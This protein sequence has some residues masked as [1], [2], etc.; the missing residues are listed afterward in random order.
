MIHSVTPVE[1]LLQHVSH[2][3]YYQRSIPGFFPKFMLWAESIQFERDIMIWNNKQYLSKPLLVKEDSAIQRHRRWYS[4]F[5]SARSVKF[6]GQKNGLDWWLQYQLALAMPSEPF[7][8]SQGQAM[9]KGAMDSL[10]LVVGCVCVHG[11]K[12]CYTE[13]CLHLR[14]FLISSGEIETLLSEAD[15]AIP[16]ALGRL[17]GS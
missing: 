17:Y 16:I 12:K 2:T 7:S 9:W 8:S 6:T 11:V 4:Q 13:C 5:Y 10:N 14:A 15:P 1:P 3:I